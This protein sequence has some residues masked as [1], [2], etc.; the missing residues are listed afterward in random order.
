M[1]YL[2]AVPQPIALFPQFIAAQP[3]TLILKEHVVSLTGDSFSIKLANGT[4]V[5]QVEGKVMSISGRKKVSDMHGNHLFDILKERLHIHATYVAKSPTGEK[6]LEVKSGFKLVGSKATA[7]FTSTSGKQE[8]LSMKGNFLDTSADI[9]DETQN[10]LVVAR[11]NRKVL[12][13]KDLLF[14]QQT[15][16]VQVAPGVDFALIAALCI[17]LDEKNNEK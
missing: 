15:Y 8:T 9:I 2:A 13:G 16:A 6:L 12:S 3:E 1:A 17:C 10:G 7:T 4:A 14:G 5:L 11:I